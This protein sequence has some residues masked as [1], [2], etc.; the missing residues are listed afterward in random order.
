MVPA[1][2]KK[3]VPSRYIIPGYYLSTNE[4]KFKWCFAVGQMVAGW[5]VVE[6]YIMYTR[7]DFE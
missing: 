6:Q 5:E 1:K 2:K 3:E 7:K 4:S